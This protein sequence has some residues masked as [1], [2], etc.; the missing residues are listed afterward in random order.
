MVLSRF[1]VLLLDCSKFYILL[2]CTLVL[3]INED[4]VD[5]FTFHVGFKLVLLVTED[6]LMFSRLSSVFCNGKHV[7][8]LA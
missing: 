1:I 4:V 8:I 7:I 6:F 2:L 5:T 3:S